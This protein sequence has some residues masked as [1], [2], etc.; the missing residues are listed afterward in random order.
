ML[1]AYTYAK[2]STCRKAVK[3]LRD[4][5]VEFK[6]LSIR[7]TPPSRDELKAML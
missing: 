1:K 4:H 5:H 3:F 7:E 2:C 6:E